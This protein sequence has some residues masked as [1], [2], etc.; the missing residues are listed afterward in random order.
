MR[1]TAGVLSAS[2]LSAIAIIRT[3]HSSQ[4]LGNINHANGSWDGAGTQ[5]FSCQIERLTK[6]KRQ[7]ERNI[8]ASLEQL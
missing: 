2:V 6:S 4:L 5:N 3:Q 7:G 1:L 8:H